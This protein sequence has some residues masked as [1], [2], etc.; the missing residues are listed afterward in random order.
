MPKLKR[1]RSRAR[2]MMGRIM[3]SISARR[4]RRVYEK[5]AMTLERRIGNLPNHEVII[6]P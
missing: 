5:A 3:E 6:A 2:S 1:I 4:T